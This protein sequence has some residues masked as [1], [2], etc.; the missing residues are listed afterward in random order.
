MAGPRHGSYGRAEDVKVPRKLAE[1]EEKAA[2]AADG[3]GREL[4]E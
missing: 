3:V 4:L 1:G 2:R